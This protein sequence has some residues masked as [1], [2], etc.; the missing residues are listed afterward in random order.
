MRKAGY[1]SL[2]PPQTLADIERRGV[3]STEPYTSMA[4]GIIEGWYSGLVQSSGGASQT[5]AWLHGLGWQA[6]GYTMAPAYC[7]GETGIWGSAPAGTPETG[8]TTA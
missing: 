7:E 5:V 2:N 4:N 6:L 8:A 1:L 3:F